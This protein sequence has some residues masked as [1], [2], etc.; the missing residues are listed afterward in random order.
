MSDIPGCFQLKVDYLWLCCVQGKWKVD[1]FWLCCVQGKWK[2][3]Y[4]WSDYVVFRVNE[5]GYSAEVAEDTGVSK[6]SHLDTTVHTSVL[7]FFIESH[8]Q[9]AIL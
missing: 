2:V 4:L 5:F 3:D 7:G 1:Y 6:V 9:L 8:S